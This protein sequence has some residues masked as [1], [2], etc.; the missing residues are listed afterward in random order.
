MWGSTLERAIL[1]TRVPD[2]GVSVGEVWNEML[3]CLHRAGG[4]YE[5]CV[6]LVYIGGPSWGRARCCSGA[7]GA[8]ELYLR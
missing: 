2:R 4:Q 7:M 1:S 8:T 3:R 6:V 5:L